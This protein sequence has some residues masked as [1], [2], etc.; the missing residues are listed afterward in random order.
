M[1][2]NSGRVN[3]AYPQFFVNPLTFST[4]TLPY[5]RVRWFD[6]EE[7]RVALVHDYLVQD[8]GAER[9]LAALQEMYPNAP[10]FV[11][12]YKADHVQAKGRAIIPSFLQRW[13]F[14]TRLYQLYMPMMPTAVESLDLSG[15]DL[16]ISTTSLFAKGVIASADA[17]HICYCHTP[18]RFLWQE[19][20]GYLSDLPYANVFKLFA[21]FH[22]LR[23]WDQLAAGRPDHLVT[24][25]TTSKERIMRC[26]RREADIIAPPVDTDKIQLSNEA[27]HYWLAG[28]RLVKYKR[29]DSLV[30][31]FNDLK[32]PLKIFGTGPEMPKLKRLAGPMINFL[33][34]VPEGEKVQLYHNAIGYIAPQIEDFGITAVEAMSA[35]KPVITC[36]K[37]GG[38]ETVVDGETGMHIAINRW[39]DIRDAVLRFDPSRFDAQRIRAHAERYSRERFQREMRLF[40]ERVVQHA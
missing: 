40:V 5:L 27:G 34:Y 12:L 21:P 9:V 35:G 15:Y 16:V 10:T 39:E 36:N 6:M 3:I 8:G 4:G 38:A 17:V 26:Y 1:P 25:S 24:N 22:Q 33:G 29:F 23:T 30:R 11:L 20:F 32:L 7:P 28:G 14:A 18:T 19:R 37:G 13:P 2:D 31:A